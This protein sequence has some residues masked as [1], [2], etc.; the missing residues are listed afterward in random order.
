MRPL[1]IGKL[2][3]IP[4]KGDER[5]V[6]AH[7]QNGRRRQIVSKKVDGPL[8]H[9]LN[10]SCGLGRQDRLHTVDF[11]IDGAEFELYKT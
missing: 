4:N 9:L 6:E 5:P 7:R 2:N 8:V 1:S 10:Q 3:S 11:Q